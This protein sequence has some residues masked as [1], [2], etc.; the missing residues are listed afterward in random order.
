MR[1]VVRVNLKGR[2][3]KLGAGRALLY[4]FFEGCHHQCRGNRNRLVDPAP[5]QADAPVQ[6][7]VAL[8]GLDDALAV[9]QHAC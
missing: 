7:Y 2:L 6:G 9:L 3:H 8:A 5:R 4:G 1:R